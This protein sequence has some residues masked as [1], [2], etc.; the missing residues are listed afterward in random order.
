MN[1][2]PWKK[3]GHVQ[4]HNTAAWGSSTEYSYRNIRAWCKVA[5]SLFLHLHSTCK[6]KQALAHSHVMHEET[7][8]KVSNS[9]LW[10]RTRDARGYEAQVFWAYVK[11]FVLVVSVSTKWAQKSPSDQSGKQSVTPRSGCMNIVLIWPHSCRYHVK[12]SPLSS[13]ETFHTFCK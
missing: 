13:V 10:V 11:L 1:I 6:C 12:E 4:K 8:L 2:N 7:Y 3:P 9:I 5:W